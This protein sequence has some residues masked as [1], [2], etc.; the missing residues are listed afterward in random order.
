MKRN[1]ALNVSI[2][3]AVLVGVA[4][5]VVGS[6]AGVLLSPQLTGITSEFRCVDCHQVHGAITL[7]DVPF[8]TFVLLT[9]DVPEPAL[10][11]VNEILP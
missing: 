8:N 5:G 1:V 2:I 9:G 3:V 6:V 10:I 4:I 11:R 7:E